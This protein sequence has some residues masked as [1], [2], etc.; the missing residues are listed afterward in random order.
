MCSQ[1]CCCPNLPIQ[2]LLQ[3]SWLHLQ[4]WIL[5]GQWKYL[6]R[7]SLRN[8]L[9]WTKL[10]FFNF[11]ITKLCS[12]LCLQCQ[13]QSM[14][15]FSSFMRKLCLFQR[16]YL[17]VLDWLQFDQRN[18]PAMP[19]RNCIRWLSMFIHHQGEHNHRLWIKSGVNQRKLCLQQ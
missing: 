8:L 12:R 19:I 11:R 16:S 15:S 13:H 17:R 18:L 9:E 7:L 14:R 5:P 4:H 2:L 1:W 6:Q 10:C 3:R